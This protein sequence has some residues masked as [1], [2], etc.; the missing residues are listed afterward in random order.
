MTILA[1]IFKVYKRRKK[2]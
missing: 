1:T 2:T